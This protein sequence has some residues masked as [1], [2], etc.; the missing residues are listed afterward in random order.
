MANNA[1]PDQLASTVRKGRVY[2]GSA[3]LGLTYIFMEK[4]EKKIISAF[5]LKK[6]PL[7]SS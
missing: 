1:D 2:P 7:V 3:G 6:D 5:C 4:L